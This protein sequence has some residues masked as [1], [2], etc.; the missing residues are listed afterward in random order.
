MPPSLWQMGR[1]TTPS[2][3][4]D[5]GNSATGWSPS[6]SDP[7]RP[8]GPSHGSRPAPAGLF[9]HVQPAGEARGPDFALPLNE[10]Q[11]PFQ[12]PVNPP[13]EWQNI[14]RD[15]EWR[16]RQCHGQDYLYQNGQ[17]RC[18]G[19][20]F[21]GFYLYRQDPHFGGYW[22]HPPRGHQPDHAPLYGVHPGPPIP[23]PSDGDYQERAESEAPTNDPVVDPD[24]IPG[25]GR[26]PRR[27]RRGRGPGQRPRQE[28]REEQ[29]PNLEIDIPETASSRPSQTSSGK[30]VA[31]DDWTSQHGP[32]KG[33][34]FR[35]GAP[36]LPPTWHYDKG[37]LKAYRK[38]EKRVRIWELQIVNYVPRKEAGILLFTSLKGELE[39]EMEDAPVDSIYCPTGID[40]ILDTI[41]KAVET[42]SVHL[43]RKLLSD[44]EHI[45]RTNGECAPT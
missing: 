3:R 22:P 35:G 17:W 41:R 19:C 29:E 16:C 27:R 15:D 4:S 39:E 45:Y 13:V 6:L 7:G 14:A 12:E 8:E 42:R 21:D 18:P 5:D 23:P 10:P 38:W 37:D 20:G 30:K 11:V 40:F 32:R 44:Y 34:K 1:P 9:A 33:L 2:A 26:Q 31:D 24:G 25:R 36:P 43:K 28:P